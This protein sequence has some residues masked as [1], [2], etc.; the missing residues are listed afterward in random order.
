VGIWGSTTCANGTSVSALFETET[1]KPA[2][3]GLFK[4]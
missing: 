1:L 3:E 4:A 2:Y